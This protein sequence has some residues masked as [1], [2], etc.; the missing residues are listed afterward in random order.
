MSKAIFLLAALFLLTET[1]DAQPRRFEFN[2]LIAHWY[3]YG[4]PDY[5]KFVEEARPE[6]C[7]VGF[8]G[9]HFWS[10]AHTPQFKGYPAHFPVQG[11]KECGD[12]FTNLNKDLHKRN[13]KVVGHFNVEFLVG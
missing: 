3:A 8:Y 1:A 7:Q 9:A 6:V 10:L 13:A 2:R 5:L 12:W 11:L 4:N